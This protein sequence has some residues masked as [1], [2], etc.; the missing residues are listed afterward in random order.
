MAR[1][2]TLNQLLNSLQAEAGMSLLPA[3]A[4]STRDHRVQLLN[5]VQ[6][7]FYAA[8]DWD[9]A[10]VKR[11]VSVVKGDR[12]L[13]LP[14]DLDFE[15]ANQTWLTEAGASDWRQLGYGVTE[16]QYRVTWEGTEGC[17]QRWGPSEGGQFE[18][19]PVADNSYTVRFRGCKVCPLMVND[20]DR[21]V[22]DDM[23]IVLHAA[24]EVMKRAKLPDWEDKLREGQT[25]FKSLRAQTGGNKR[26]PIVSGGGIS[27][28]IG[29]APRTPVP[30]LDYIP[31]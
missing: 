17:P 7:R 26:R 10:W 28:L 14:N 21:A 6:A 15:R 3:S 13:N 19:W 4:V 2:R 16:A 22:L 23:L 25:H 9:F 29:D 5:R 11:D 1:A 18:L 27:G 8:W 24:S 12:Y 20:S 31:S 30:G